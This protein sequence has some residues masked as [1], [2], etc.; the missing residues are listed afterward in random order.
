MYSCET[1][2]KGA[3]ITEMGAV[4]NYSTNAIMKK[5]KHKQGRRVKDMEFLGVLEK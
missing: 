2:G 3:C 1:V 5:K 4:I